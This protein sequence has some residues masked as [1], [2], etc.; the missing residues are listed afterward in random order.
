[1]IAGGGTGGH[2]FPA[3]AVGDEMIRRG[4]ELI[5][6]GSENGFE[7]RKIPEK[8]WRF[9]AM[10]A[11][12]W[13]G[14][15]AVAKFK[16]VFK[17]AKGFMEA[18]RVLKTERPDVVIGVGG[19]V[20]V[21]VM[22]AASIGGIQTMIMEQNAIPGLANRILSRFARRICITFPGSAHYFNKR[23]VVLTGNPVRSEIIA[24]SKEARGSN[25]KFV[26]FCFGGSQGAKTIS[27]GLLS[28]LD[29][30]SD[31]KEGLRIIHQIGASMNESEVMAIYR[32]KGFDAEVHTFINDMA[33]CYVQADMVISR[34]GATSVAEL[35]VMGK[36]ALLIPYPFAAD[37][38]QEFN[39]KSLVDG[40][41]AE[42]IL[43]K[44]VTGEKL[45]VVIRKMMGNRNLLDEMG[46]AM[47]KMAKPDAAVEI[48]NEAIR[49]REVES[50]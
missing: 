18:R 20:S 37:N 14:K 25:D 5:Y 6:V 21:P 43:N 10:K 3:I 7:A 47:R 39:A 34:S 50:V 33:A 38:H 29:H 31:V 36:P 17:V 4:V 16:T 41:G 15:G 24:K 45:A 27:E 48:V 30:L 35:M 11:G 9:I 40:G 2:V 13:K 1:M 23:K 12:Q 22:C 44:D 32:S 26:V 42:M 49:L 46:K 28:A 19:Y 8:G